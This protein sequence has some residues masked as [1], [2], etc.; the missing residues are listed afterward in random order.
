MDE[1]LSGKRNPAPLTVA[2]IE[3]LPTFAQHQGW[4]AAAAFAN[5]CRVTQPPAENA[6]LQALEAADLALLA[7]HLEPIEVQAGEILY[8]P[9]EDVRFVHFPTGPVLLSFMVVFEEGASV[10]TALIGREGALGGIVSQGN[11]PAYARTQ[12]QYP[13]TLLRMRTTVL[14][15]AKAKSRTLDNLFAR[16][17]D[18][19]L[20]QIFQSV[21]CSATHGVEARTARWLLSAQDRTGDPLVPVTQERLAAMLG[22]GRSYVSRVI[23]DLKA[24]D[25]I[26]VRPGRITIIDRKG[27]EHRGCHCTAAVRAHFDEVLRGVYPRVARS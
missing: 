13:G 2:P 22:V 27:L 25:A 20:A 3:W 7:P 16:Y 23:S 1:N 4:H 26:D 15:V 10:E 6:L 8:E 14:E 12:V 17:A 9:G 21:A 24:A 11:L 18:C 5:A 19:L